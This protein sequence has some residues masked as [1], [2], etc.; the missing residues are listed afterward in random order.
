MKDI[1][2]IFP[3]GLVIQQ[4]EI[5]EYQIVRYHPKKYKDGFSTKEYD[6]DTT[7]YHGFINGNDT[8]HSFHSL[9]AC[10][11]G[12]IGYKH[13]GPNEGPRAGNFFIKMLA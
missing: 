4:L 3:W 11:A 7:E 6:F 1:D 8:C 13:L 9:D 2:K 12:L 5:G 10:L